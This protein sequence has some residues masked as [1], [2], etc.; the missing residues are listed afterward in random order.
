MSSNKFN[1]SQDRIKQLKDGTIFKQTKDCCENRTPSVT[2]L[3]PCVPYSYKNKH[4]R[5][6][7]N[8]LYNNQIKAL[9]EYQSRWKK[10]TKDCCKDK[11]NKLT[12][13]SSYVKK[14]KYEL[15]NSQLH[16]IHTQNLNAKDERVRKMVKMTKNDYI[17]TLKFPR[18][19]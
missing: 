4:A 12:Y 16:S 18:S 11:S 5:M 2:P 17:H 14:D 9:R 10:N 6:N 13:S 1:S 8:K 15:F 19:R 3:K 7:N